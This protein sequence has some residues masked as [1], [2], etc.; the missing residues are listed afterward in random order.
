MNTVRN[1]PVEPSV[2]K[3]LDPY[4]TPRTIPGGWDVSVIQIGKKL[5]TVKSPT[6][7]PSVAKMLDPYSTPR[8]IPGGWDVSAF[9]R[10]DHSSV[11]TYGDASHQ[12]NLTA[13][14]TG[15]NESTKNSL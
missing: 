7:E 3:M 2:A 4:S 5:D 13:A 12:S 14:S 1:A 10:P 15:T 11:V 8:T 9:S 6:V